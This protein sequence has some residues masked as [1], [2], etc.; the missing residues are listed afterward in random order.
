[1]TKQHTKDMGLV[2]NTQ[3]YSVHDGHGIRTLIFLMGCPLN[4]PWCSN[5]ESQGPVRQV[6][7]NKDGVQETLGEWR[8]V[9]DVVD[10]VMRD[11]VFYDASGGG[12]TLSG[13]EVLV[14]YEFAEQL[15]KRFYT[16]GVSTA[17]ETTG[18]LQVERI[19]RLLPYLDQVLFDLKIMDSAQGRSV[20]G[21]N[22]ETVKE[23]FEAALAAKHVKVTPRVPLIPEYTA[24]DNNLS[25]IAKYLVTVGVDEV[26]LLPFH[27][28][29][30]QKYNYLEREYT[31]KDVDTL[32]QEQ[33]KAFREIFESRGVRT[34]VSGLD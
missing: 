4:C 17:I 33:I 21:Y 34:N 26:H 14:Q 16:L 11:Q 28:Y 15:L 18:A 25:D 2:L 27:Q 7:W 6:T 13:G 19:E 8:T 24:V 29:G 9:D 5:P 30:S 32:E 1:M 23:N 3:R 22:I 31:M 20:I 12:V 10:E